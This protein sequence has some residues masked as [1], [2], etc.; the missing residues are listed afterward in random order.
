MPLQIDWFDVRTPREA[1]PVSQLLTAWANAQGAVWTFWLGSLEPLTPA[2]RLRAWSQVSQTV[3][4]AAA[5]STKAALE[6]QVDA[7]RACAERIAA[8]PKSSK[9]V[10]EAAHQAYDLVVAFSE[11]AAA[12]CD[13]SLAASRCGEAAALANLAPGERR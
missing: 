12:T 2:D 7:A 8:H 3:G 4:A 6:L 13:A 1:A 10:V 11:A 9:L 5:A